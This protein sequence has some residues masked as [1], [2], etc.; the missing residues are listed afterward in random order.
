[1]LSWSHCKHRWPVQGGKLN[2]PLQ[3][4]EL[5][6]H[7]LSTSCTPPHIPCVT[8]SWV[9]TKCLWANGTLSGLGL[10]NKQPLCEMAAAEDPGFGGLQGHLMEE[11]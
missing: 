3:I 7:R 8:L 4:S 1:L 10:L 5:H 6:P 9:R 11:P 2:L